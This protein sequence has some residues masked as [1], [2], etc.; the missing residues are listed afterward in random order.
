MRRHFQV[1]EPDDDEE[2]ERNTYLPFHKPSN[3]S[4]T[5]IIQELSKL[6]K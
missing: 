2:T 1:D 5:N 6:K 4:P 3:K